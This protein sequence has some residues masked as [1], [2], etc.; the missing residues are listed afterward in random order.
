MSERAKYRG[1]LAEA[2]EEERRLVLKMSGLRQSIR[3]R[4]DLVKDV[5]EID[6][7]LIAQQAI[8]F[9]QAQIELT[10]KRAEIKTIK[11]VLGD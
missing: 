1:Y 6:G 2:Q 8:E 4:M 3:D 5:G 10:A 11:D 7:E 9:R